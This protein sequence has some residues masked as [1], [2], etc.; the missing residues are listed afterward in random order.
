MKR[1]L[2][3]ITSLTM[4]VVAFSQQSYSLKE[5]IDYSLKNH[6]SNEIYNNELEKVRL[7][8]KEALSAY[9]PQV[10]G[11]ITFDD[12]IKRQTTILPGA[13]FGS[14][15]DI[16]V[17]FGNKYNSGAMM[18]LD[19][20]IYDQALLYGIKAGVP[21]QRIAELKISKNN[22]ELIYNT[23]AAYSQILILKEQQRLLAANEKQYHDLF[24]ITKFRFDKGVAKK[25]DMDRVTVQLNNIKSQQKQIQTDI[26]VSY[27]ALKNAMGL[28]LDA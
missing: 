27:N 20:T 11:N 25:V 18:Q 19:Q 1:T 13:M 2:L 9:L 4:G 21:S 6:G 24:D 7:Q 8:S 26:D 23:A 15:K 14:E 3:F 17:Q 22:E 12:N 28:P 16:P 5:A 10:N